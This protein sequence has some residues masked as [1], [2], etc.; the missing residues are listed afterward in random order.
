MRSRRGSRLRAPTRTAAG[1]STRCSAT[2]ADGYVRGV[3]GGAGALSLARCAPGARRCLLRCSRS[4]AGALALAAG[5]A[6][7]SLAASLGWRAAGSLTDAC[8]LPALPPCAV[9]VLSLQ[10]PELDVLQEVE[11]TITRRAR[12]GRSRRGA[13]AARAARGLRCGFVLRARATPRVAPPDPRPRPPPPSRAAA[14]RRRRSRRCW[15]RS[16]R[17]RARAATRED[18]ELGGSCARPWSMRVTESS[19]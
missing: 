15:P 14:A 8:S 9:G 16:S 10:G 5:A 1:S 2:P 6:A 4:R 13:R 12:E 17:R 11:L 19:K 7:R 3:G 18:E